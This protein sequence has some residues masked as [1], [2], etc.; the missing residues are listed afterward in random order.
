[1]DH[2]DDFLLP[3]LDVTKSQYHLIVLN[4]PCVASDLIRRLWR[5]CIIKICADGGANR[6]FS[7]L[8]D[9]EKDQFIPNFITGDLDSLQSHVRDYYSSLNV[10]IIQDPDQDSHDLDKSL[11]LLKESISSDQVAMTSKVVVIGGTGG[12]IDQQIAVFNTLYS[13]SNSFQK[14][15][16]VDDESIAYLLQS[17]VEHKISPIRQEDI[18]QGRYCGLL[19][20]GNPVRSIRT[21]GLVWNLNNEPLEFGKRISTSNSIANSDNNEVDST[22][23]T[24]YSTDPILWTT[25]W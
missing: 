11:K 24:I 1:M 8:S 4:S 14:I 13:W 5:N 18:Y 15:L 21:T 7:A 20:L 2:V 19:P 25:T 23:V 12:R 9:Q 6:L 22:F 16:I 3:N 10:P 17:N